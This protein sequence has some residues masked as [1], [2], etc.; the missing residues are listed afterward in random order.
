MEEHM[1]MEEYRKKL[2]QQLQGWQSKVDNFE[3]NN[4]PATPRA[5]ADLNRE[6]DQLL[7]K[8]EALVERWK[9]LQQAHSGEWE[10]KKMRVEKAGVELK[11]ALDRVSSRFK[12]K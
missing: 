7:Q 5:K 2:K 8:K 3:K 10:L 9:A 4:G 6:I 12:S 11:D 1:D